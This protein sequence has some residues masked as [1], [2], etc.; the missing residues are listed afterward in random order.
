MSA[1]CSTATDASAE[2]RGNPDMR[3]ASNLGASVETV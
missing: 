3:G 1:L 2:I